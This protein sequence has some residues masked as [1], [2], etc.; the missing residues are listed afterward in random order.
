MRR[1]RRVGA[2]IEITLYRAFTD[3]EIGAV[4]VGD[5]IAG[6]DDFVS[7]GGFAVFFNAHRHNNRLKVGQ[8]LYEAAVFSF[9]ADLREIN[10]LGIDLEI[11][12]SFVV[13]NGSDEK[14]KTAVGVNGVVTLCAF[15]TEIILE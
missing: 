2:F 10:A 1:N 7:P 5:K 15:A 6:D 14:F 11:H 12:I 8:F 4:K 9:F 13:F 3:A